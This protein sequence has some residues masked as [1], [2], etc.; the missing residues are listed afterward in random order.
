MNERPYETRREAGELNAITVVVGVSF[1]E[2]GMAAWQH[3]MWYANLRPDIVVHV[4]YV[5]PS[6]DDPAA[7]SEVLDEGERLLRAYLQPGLDQNPGISSRVHLHLG[8]S[9]PAEE[10]LQ[11][12]TDLEAD[13]IIVGA[14]HRR[15]MDPILEATVGERIV[16]AAPCT[17]FVVRAKDYEG[18]RKS[19]SI[20]PPRPDV[21]IGAHGP[22][23]ARPAFRRPSVS[24]PQWGGV[25]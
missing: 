15:R 25:E 13:L 19:P 11:L 20:E 14:H 6:V 1:D 5:C 21:D 24:I 17:V 9:D 4:C 3:G 12:A 23:F 18:L 16:S 10:V 8:I 22:A 2:T 7:Q